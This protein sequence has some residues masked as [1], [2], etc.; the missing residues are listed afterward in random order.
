M[1]TFAA[2]ADAVRAQH[3][4]D[5]DEA[6]AFA[7]TLHHGARA[8]RVMVRSYEA[9]GEQMV[10]IRSA[11]AE[12]RTLGAPSLLESNLTLPIG[13]VAQHGKFLVIVQK[14][15]LV[16]TSVEGLMFLLDRVGLLADLL[17]QREG[18]DRF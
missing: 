13:A 9:L 4:L 12:A 8:Q 5:R 1:A 2:F 6:D 17:E 18:T 11:F 7:V 15:V 10:E 16:H 3:P 14:A